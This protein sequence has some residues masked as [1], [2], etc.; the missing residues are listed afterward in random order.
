MWSAVINFPLY[1]VLDCICVGG[2]IG[3]LQIAARKREREVLREIFHDK[4]NKR[5]WMGMEECAPQSCRKL[6]EGSTA[7][8]N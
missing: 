4:V 7:A 6:K 5:K 1:F 8:R 3:V 2:K